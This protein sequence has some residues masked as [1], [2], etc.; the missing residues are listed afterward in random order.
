MGGDEEKMSVST[1]VVQSDIEDTVRSKVSGD[2]KNGMLTVGQWLTSV[3]KGW[4]GRGGG[5][6]GAGAIK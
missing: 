3:S 1:C 4:V 2:L 5:W 6:G